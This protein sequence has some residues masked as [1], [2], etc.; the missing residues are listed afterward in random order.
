MLGSIYPRLFTLIVVS[1]SLRC[2]FL[3]VPEPSEH[4][5]LLID[6]YFYETQVPLAMRDIAIQMASNDCVDSPYKSPFGDMR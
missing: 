1:F 2:E 5:H 3:D 4:E 6:G